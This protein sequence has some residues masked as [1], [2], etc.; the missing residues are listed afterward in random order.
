MN[1]LSRLRSRRNM[2]DWGLLSYGHLGAKTS[3]P[4]T[5]RLLKPTRAISE[6]SQAVV[7]GGVQ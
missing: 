1:N 5:T 6:P 4:I 7:A 2:N 3:S